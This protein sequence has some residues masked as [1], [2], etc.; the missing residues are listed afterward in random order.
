MTGRPLTEWIVEAIHN[1]GDRAHLQDIYKEVLRLGYD[2]GGKDLNKLIRSRILENSSDSRKYTRRRNL[3][4]TPS[5][6]SGIWELRGTP[7]SALV[8]VE[9]R[10][11]TDDEIDQLLRAN[12]LRIGIVPTDNLQAQARRRRGQDRIRVLTL[13]NYRSR[14][15]VCDVVDRA[16]LLAS[17]VVGWAEAPEHRGDLSNVMCLC[18]IH[19]ALFEAGYWSLGNDL[20]LLKRKTVSSEALR[21][22]LDGMTA[23]R[24]PLDFP[25]ARRF[26]KSHRKKAG[27]PG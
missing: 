2:R 15:A 5:I 16:L 27:F 25:P 6:R 23:F 26:L 18:R 22:I 19:D 13:K 9:E 10:D 3:F 1:L 11:R 4:H 21:Q 8:D 17:H 14:C 7:A 12:R 20:K 24:R